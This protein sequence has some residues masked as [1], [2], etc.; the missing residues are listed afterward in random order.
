MAAGPHSI[1]AVYGGDA[2]FPAAPAA[3][4]ETV[5]KDQHGSVVSSVNPAVSGQAVTFTDAVS[6]VARRRR[7]HGHRD[8]QGRRPSLDTGTLSGGVAT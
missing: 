8:V 1:T 6:A 3:L 5:G 4:S 7:G 2:N